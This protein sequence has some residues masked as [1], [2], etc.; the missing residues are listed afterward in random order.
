MRQNSS[1][2]LK[3]VQI[4]W[5]FGNYMNSGSPKGNAPGFQLRSLLKLKETKSS[6]NKYTLLHHIVKHCDGNHKEILDWVNDLQSAKYASK[7]SYQT[8]NDDFVELEKGLDDVEK[9]IPLVGNSNY[10]YDVFD[11]RMP[12]QILDCRKKFEE[13]KEKKN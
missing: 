3:L 2:F 5:A 1:N 6:E 8:I 7:V 10:R 13:F 4:V 12:D 11:T 9:K